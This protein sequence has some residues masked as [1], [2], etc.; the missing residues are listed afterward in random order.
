[1]PDE[2]RL[3]CLCKCTFEST[4]VEEE[5]CLTVLGNDV[6]VWAMAV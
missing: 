2:S 4:K 6:L 5:K 3:L 1:M